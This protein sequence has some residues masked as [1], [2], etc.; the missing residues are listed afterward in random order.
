[1]KKAILIDANHLLSRTFHVP[2]FQSMKSVVD[3]EV[4]MTGATFGFICSLKN[5]I[6]KHQKPDDSLVVI[7]D[8]GRGFRKELSVEYKANRSSRTPEFIFQLEL[9][10]EFLRLLGVMQCQQIDAE[11]DDIIAVLAQRARLKNYDVLIISGDKDFNQIVDDHVNVL[12]PKGGNEYVLMTPEKV[13]EHYGIPPKYF[14]D[15]LALLGDSSDNVKGIDGVGKKTAMKLILG[16]GS[17]EDII[18][19]NQ[20]FEIDDNNS[21]KPVS[22]KLQAKINDSKKIIELSK[23]LVLLRTDFKDFNSTCDEPDFI[24]LKKL[25]KKY[26]F[27]SFLAGFS[28]FVTMFS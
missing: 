23:K 9:T 17:I 12:N 4:V 7:W 8:G 20:H 15:Y 16:N 14:A 11:A 18:K 6:E 25:F 2:A 3:D 24:A 1:M 5:I 21:K 13:E 22:S 27:K 10:Q 26:S 28:E 19:A